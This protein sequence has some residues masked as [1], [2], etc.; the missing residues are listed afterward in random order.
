MN[1]RGAA[2]DHRPTLCYPLC[3]DSLGGSHHSLLGLLQQLD[4]NRYRIVVVVEKLGG[5]L[6][7]FFA[8]FDQLE[9]PAAPRDP[10]VA[11]N[12]QGLRE[13]LGTFSGLR[14]RARFLREHNVRIVHT[15]DGRSHGTWALPARLS[16][17]RLLWHH[18]ADPQARGLRYLAPLLADQIVTVSRFS[19]PRSIA[20]KPSLKAEVVFSPFD[21]D[22]V[23]DREQQR[24]RLCGELGLPEDAFIVGYFG[25][26]IDRK[27]PVKFVEALSQLSLLLSRPAYGVIFGEAEDPAIDAMVRSRIAQLGLQ[28]NVF[29]MGYRSPGAEWI[30]ACDALAVPAVGEPLGRT[31][32]EAM[33]VG[34]PVVATSSG[35]NPEAILEGLGVLVAP[36]D[37]LA[38]AQGCA[39]VSRN[40]PEVTAMIERAR[41][42]AKA[43]FTREQHLRAIDGIYQRLLAGSR[44]RG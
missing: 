12:P 16:G 30:A 15:N 36:D 28:Q 3:G 40:T 42:S 24:L 13:F 43:R 27:R 34:T 32:V 38:M 35:G 17:A 2:T 44:T 39:G 19:L 8:G 18:R 11:G 14:T 21:T 22:I 33:V 5:K 6:S 20:E 23:V 29:M 37:P 7:R 31:L 1:G 4:R 10:L 25:N 41:E 9:D 26:L